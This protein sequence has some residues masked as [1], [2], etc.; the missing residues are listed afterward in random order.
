MSQQFRRPALARLSQALFVSA[1]ITLGSAQ[2]QTVN[3][4]ILQYFDDT[5]SNDGQHWNR[6][7]DAAP[8]WKQKGI[9]AFWLPPAYKGSNGINDVGYAVYDLWDLGEYNQ[10]GAVRTKYG[11]KGDYI[12]AIDAIR[13]TGA[14]VYGDIVMNHKLGAEGRWGSDAFEDIRGTPVNGEN[15]LQETGAE[16]ALRVATYFA[17]P[18]RRGADG[19]LQRNAFEW[20]WYHFDGADRAQNQPDQIYRFSGVGK[21]WDTDVS[22][23]KGNYDYLL[24]MDV[25]FQHPEVRNH[26]KE[27]GVWYTREAKLDGFRIDATKHISTSYMNE[28]LYHVRQTTG[29]TNA[30][31]VSEYW[32]GD[33]NRLSGYLN[34]AN[35]SANDRLSAFDVPLHYRFRDAADANGFYNMATLLND[36]LVAWQPLRAVTFVDNHDTLA[37]RGLASPVADWF[38]PLAYSVILLRQS[39]Y[40]AVFVGDHA[41]VPGKTAAHGWLIDQMLKARQFHAYGK[42]NDYFDH[43]DLVGWTREGD[44][45]HWYGHAVLLNDNRTAAGSKWMYVGAAHANQCFKDVTNAL[46]DT[47]CANASG[48]A[49]FRAPAGKATVWVRQGK[50]GVNTN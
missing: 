6:V 39:G 5:T 41:G 49:E 18:G 3:G 34:S 24:G 22:N 19:R 44:I 12:A 32:D 40:P 36:T 37:G 20:H 21:F 33:I 42:Q 46:P 8:T 2:A 15:R 9:T 7:K 29:K 1:L 27:W 4:V 26:L 31:A 23:E 35:S 13:A 11:T 43:P 50:F 38:K 45:N 25:D 16:R 30:F 17:F 14:Q 47:I 48:W 28:W 10:K